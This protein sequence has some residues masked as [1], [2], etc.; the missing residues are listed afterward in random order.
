MASRR[1]TA[2]V[3][4]V[5]F[6][7]FL[8]AAVP[9][10]TGLAFA[11]SGRQAR[12][13][14]S[15]GHRTAPERKSTHAK[16]KPAK[17]K[18]AKRKPAK[19]K[20][21][22]RKPALKMIWGPLTLPNGSSAFPIY[23]ELGV[24]VLETQLLWARV[25][26]TRPGEPTNPADPAYRWPPELE[27]MI[28]Q[29][30]QYG[31]TVAV[32][33]KGA[34]AWAN[35]GQ[36]ESWAPTNASDYANFMTAASRRYPTVRYWMVWGEPTRPGNFNPMPANSP[37]GPKRYALL[38]DAAYGALKAVSPSNIVIGGMTYTYGLDNPPEFI[39]WMRLPDGAPPRLDYY[40]QNPYSTRYPGAEEG[41]E[42]GLAPSR[43]RP[44]L[45]PLPYRDIDALNTL[46]SELA[47]V[48]RHRPG[49]TPKLWI[50]EFSISSDSPNRAFA[51]FVS[52]PVQAEWLKAAFKLVDSESYVAG[53]GWYDLIDESAAIPG[54]LTEG[55]LAE[56]GSPKPAFNAYARAP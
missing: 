29:A 46:H 51:F 37:V 13:T 54:H 2:I 40:G 11:S 28:D 27:Q 14:S 45:K 19:H 31:I 6:S 43:G 4:T 16:H 21:A 5:A 36:E 33:V 23:H 26:T 47:T 55:L 24:Q 49:G 52:R 50:S 10:I 22:K 42:L 56:N 30:A 1:A 3:V 25:A 8:A 20:P 15:Q 32:M 38:L 18:P 34:P 44:K 17:H 35:G 7:G 41:P 9:T 48:Y 39:R 12:S 53:L